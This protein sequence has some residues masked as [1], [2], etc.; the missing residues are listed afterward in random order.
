MN[1]H[2]LRGIACWHLLKLK[3]KSCLEFHSSS[4]VNIYFFVL[5]FLCFCC[6]SFYVFLYAFSV[7]LF[8]LFCCTQP[9]SLQITLSLSPFDQ[10][11]CRCSDHLLLAK[12][13]Q[14]IQV[15]L[16]SIFSIFQ[17]YGDLSRS[18]QLVCSDIRVLNQTCSQQGQAQKLG[19]GMGGTNH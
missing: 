6:V 19:V 16:F 13:Y 17:F 3:V 1:S 7:M 10:K 2:L 5:L 8:V 9:S 11:Y 18:R 4:I 14:G 15:T 12:L